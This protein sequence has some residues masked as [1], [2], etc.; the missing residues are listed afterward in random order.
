MKRTVIVLSVLAVMGI[1]ILGTYSIQKKSSTVENYQENK[2]TTQNI[3]TGKIIKIVDVDEVLI[4][5]TKERGNLF[6]GDIVVRARPCLRFEFFVFR[7]TR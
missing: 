1:A 2:H 7:K 6:L 4:E 5:I 3:M